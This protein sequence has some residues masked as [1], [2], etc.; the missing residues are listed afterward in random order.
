MYLEGIDLDR[1]NLS[2]VDWELTAPLVKFGY[3]QATEGSKIINR[4]FLRDW[5][6]LKRLNIPRGA[7]HFLDPVQDVNAQVRNFLSVIGT[8]EVGDLPPMVCLAGEWQWKFVALGKRAPLILTFAEAVEKALGVRP[9][10]AL[11][12]NFAHDVLGTQFVSNL[13]RFKLCIVKFWDVPEPRVPEPWK[14]FH[15]WRYDDNGCFDGVEGRVHKTRFA[16]DDSDLETLRA[17]P[18]KSNSVRHADFNPRW[19]PPQPSIHI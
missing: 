4:R 17:K 10:I 16:G 5:A 12:Y 3:V 1:W 14:R 11:T 6:E 19:L 8:P 2:H 9:V 13:R 18:E 15:F 7:Y